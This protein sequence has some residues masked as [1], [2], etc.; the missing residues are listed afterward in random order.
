MSAGQSIGDAS[1]AEVAN[2]Y[3]ASGFEVEIFTGDAGLKAFEPSVKMEIPR[4]KRR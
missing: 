4:R 3:S 2:Y 1:I